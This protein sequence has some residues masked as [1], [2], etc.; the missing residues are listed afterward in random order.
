M[1]LYPFPLTTDDVFLLVGVLAVCLL[2][3]ILL[4]DR[5]LKSL[6]ERIEHLERE[7]GGE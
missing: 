2:V 5:A 4:G 7:N 3:V 6:G 1:T